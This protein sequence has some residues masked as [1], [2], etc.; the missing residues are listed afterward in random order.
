MYN[1]VRFEN[2]LNNKHT[3]LTLKKS[4]VWAVALNGWRV[5]VFSAAALSSSILHKNKII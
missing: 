1:K 2:I 5:C 3:S 4:W